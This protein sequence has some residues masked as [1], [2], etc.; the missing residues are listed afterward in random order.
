M[1]LLRG[2]RAGALRPQQG[3]AATDYVLACALLALAWSLG[4]GEPLNQ[5]LTSI[6]QRYQRL[7][8]SMA[9]P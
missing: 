4:A 8:W 1:N 5:L 6:G 3:Q 7:T 2:L 9:Q